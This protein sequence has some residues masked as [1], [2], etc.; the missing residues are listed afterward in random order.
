MAEREQPRQRRTVTVLGI[1]MDLGQ[2]RRGVDMGPSA[3]RYA[4]LD[5]RLRRVGFQVEDRGN[6]EIPER[7]TLPAA[8][9]FSFLPAVVQACEAMYAA[10]RDAMAAG[11]LPL[12]IGGDHSISVGTIG[13][14]TASGPSGVLWIDAHGDYN[15][16]ETSPSGNIHGMPLAALCGRG[17]RELVDIGRPGA[18]LRCND[19]AMIGIRDLDAEERVALRESGIAIYTMRDIDDRGIA[20]V[21]RQAL[22]DLAHLDRIHVSLDMDCMD[23]DEAPGVGTPVPGGLSYREA[24]LL[25]E[26]ICEDGRVGSIDVVEINPILDLRNRTAEIALELLSSLLGKTIL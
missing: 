6:V 26:L 24:H 9:G 15:T 11:N 14:A 3:L 25:M 5:E 21:A 23:P 12:F 20:D 19:V 22:R 17:A 8:G 18:K 1:P 13:G 2:M 4:G 7:E 10:S 16:P